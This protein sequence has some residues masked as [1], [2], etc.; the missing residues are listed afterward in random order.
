MKKRFS[1]PL[2]HPGENV[3]ARYPLKYIDVFLTYNTDAVK[4]R[5][6]HIEFESDP[7]AQKQP[8]C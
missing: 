7:E 8:K 5:S 2:A 4:N 3:I 6:S 1:F